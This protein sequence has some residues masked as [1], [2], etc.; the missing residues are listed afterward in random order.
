VD[1]ERVAQG[2]V[3]VALG[4]FDRVMAEKF[5]DVAYV[6]TVFQKVCSKRMAQAVYARL[7]V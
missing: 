2:N 5:L 6:R 4:R 3:R 1:N 7:A